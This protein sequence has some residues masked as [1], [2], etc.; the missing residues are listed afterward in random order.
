MEIL[1]EKLIKVLNKKLHIDYEKNYEFKKYSTIRLGKTIPL[2]IYPNTFKKLQKLI[3]ILYKMRINYK[4]VGNASNILINDD[5]LVIISLRKIKPYIVMKKNYFIVSSNYS[6][7][8][9]ALLAKEGIKTFLGLTKIPGTL[10]G[11]IYNNSSV[12]SYQVSDD[13]VSIM[14][15]DKYGR[16]KKMNK[17]DINFKYRYSNISIFKGIIIEGIFK[18][19][20]DI[21]SYNIYKKLDERR[22]LT[23]P[24]GYSLGSIYKNGNNYFAGKLIE[25]VSLKGY[26][27]NGIKISDLHANIIIN[28]GGSLK[29]FLEL[30][31][32]IE[33]KVLLKY[34]IRLEKEIEIINNV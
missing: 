10:G 15:F 6:S 24:K 23:Q 13:L 22:N 2:L 3:K 11:A 17:E 18:R 34:G 32:I 28:E 19:V 7:V 25:N 21:N 9:L 29:D 4:V 33:L 1:Y 31:F 16:L 30:L 14:Y 12:G 5:K 27:Y 26:N 20:V 8:R